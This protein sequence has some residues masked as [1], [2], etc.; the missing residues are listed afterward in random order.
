MG[1]DSQGLSCVPPE[2][3]VYP[4]WSDVVCSWICPETVFN[5][6]SCHGM[7]LWRTPLLPTLGRNK[8][9]L[10]LEGARVGDGTGSYL[11]LGC[12]GHS[13]HRGD[14]GEGAGRLIGVLLP[15]DRVI[16]K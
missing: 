6:E 13:P 8:R 2:T 9:H 3:A 15:G 1:D 4:L 16:R 5:E 10:C 14:H 7:V 12:V 11:T